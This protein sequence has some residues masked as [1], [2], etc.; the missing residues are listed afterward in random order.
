MKGK[1]K[2]ICWNCGKEFEVN[3]TNRERKFCPNSNCYNEYK[4]KPEYIKYLK[5]RLIAAAKELKK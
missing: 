2:K 5:D 1:I 4:Q 3:Y